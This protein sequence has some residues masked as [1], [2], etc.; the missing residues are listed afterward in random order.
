MRRPAPIIATHADAALARGFLHQGLGSGQLGQEQSHF[1][2]RSFLAQE[3][4]NNT[5]G[6]FGGGLIDAD[7]GD[8]T[9]NQFVH[10]ASRQP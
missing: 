7:I 3:I 2:G 9:P 10:C 4:G 8:E 5:H 1:V 6:C